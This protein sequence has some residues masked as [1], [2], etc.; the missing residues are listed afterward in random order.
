MKWALLA[1][2]SAAVALGLSAEWAALQRAPLEQAASSEDIR[3]AVG[4]LIVGWTF[5]A[6]GMAAWSRRSESRIGPLLALVG[7]SWFLGTFASSSIGALAGFGAAMVTLHRGP[8]VHALLSYPSGRLDGRLDRAVVALG[9]VSA[10]I[11]DVGQDAAATLALAAVILA[12]ATRRYRRS[13]GPS[14]RAVAP[15]LAATAAYVSVLTASSLADFAAAG[16]TTARAVLWAYEAVLVVIAVLFLADLLAGRWTQ[17]TV[18]GLVVDLGRVPEEGTLRQRL[19]AALGDR[20]L[21]IGYWLPDAAEYV[22]EAGR[23]LELP[24][25]GSEREVTLLEGDGDRLAVLVHD[26]GVLEDREL[27]DSV[28]A[29]ARIAVSNVRLQAQI[30]RQVENLEASRRR[31]VAAADTQRRRLERELHDGAELRLARVKTLLRSARTNGAAAAMVAE[32]QSELER[33]EAELHELARGIHPRVLT[34][35]GL[36]VALAEVA[37][38][39]GV[40]VHVDAPAERFP[41]HVEAAAYFVC[42]EALANVGKHAQA[43]EATI[44][45]SRS[46]SRLVVV[47]RDDGVGGAG[48][49]KGSG[50]RGLADRVEAVGGRL[51]VASPT[52]QGTVLV[53]QLPLI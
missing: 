45:V 20:S 36:A 10:A 47:V 17:A 44:D 13:T 18:T 21:T 38:T 9:Y 49:D 37:R 27:M 12:T 24:G 32:A 40:P 11:V 7:F 26:A 43:S 46:G 52:G 1:L 33:A 4:D 31:I 8:L 14:R 35:G 6:A 30:R 51:S 28:A 15:A 2:A 42:S 29:A 19:A 22:D 25:R 41:A 5:I 53:A 16:T 39:A 50:L 23:P 3:L 48:L 34:E